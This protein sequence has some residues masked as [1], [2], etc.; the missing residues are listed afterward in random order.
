MK[1]PTYLSQTDKYTLTI[2]DFY[3]SFEKYI[4]SAIYNLYK[5]GAE[6]IT[7]VDIDN[8]F[9]THDTAKKIFEKNNGIEYLQD[10]LEF[11]QEENFPFYYRRLKKFNCLNDLKK[12]GYDTSKIYVEDLTNLK[13]KEVNEKFETLELEDIFMTIKKEIMSI[14]SKYGTGDASE[15]ESA[16][17][18]IKEL[19]KELQKTPDVG[20][21]LQG[22]IFNTICRG[23]RSTKYY[24]RSADSG[25]GKALPNSTK[26]PTPDGFKRVDEIKVGDYLFDA[27][28]KPTRILGVYPQGIKDVYY[29]LFKDG[30]KALCCED[31]LWSYCTTGQNKKFKQQR[32]FYTKTLKELQQLELKTQNHGYQILIPMNYAAQYSK[33]EY[34]IP[35]YVFGLALGDGSFRQNESNKSFQYSSENEYLPNCIGEQMGWIVKKGSAHNYT[36]YFSY[37]E[38]LKNNKKNIWVEDFLKQFPQLINAK[39]ED[40]FIPELY[41]FGD[42]QQRLDLLNGLLD[43]DGSVDN[44]GR[45]NFYTIS[46]KLR[47]NV[48]D[49]CHSLGFKI[50]QE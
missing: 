35:P 32:K 29:V 26:I 14:E 28:G 6:Y 23:A 15:T 46:E 41:M 30:R 37:K 12:A 17:D 44:K 21:P 16:A 19:I 18:G 22:K 31:H 43:S 24:V 9:N 42:V 20:A 38:E 5:G 40:K 49:L 11:C 8:Y 47:D 2:Y 50:M 27:F 1:H 33:K 39:S 3:S 4:F 36:W 7:E 34:Y 10:A 45:V 25:T 13:A 48:V